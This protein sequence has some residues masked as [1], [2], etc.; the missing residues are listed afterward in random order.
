MRYRIRPLAAS[1]AVRLVGVPLAL[2][3]L[4]ACSDDVTS[5]STPIRPASTPTLARGGN[6][7]NN[8]RIVFASVRDAPTFQLYSMNAD[9]TGVS[10]LTYSPGYDSDPAVSP[11]GKRIVFQSNRD[12]PAASE[13]YVMNADG[14]GVTRLTYSLGGDITPAWSP[15]GK[16]IAFAS[17]RNAASPAT[18]SKDALDIYVMNADGSSVTQL[19]HRVGVDGVPSWSPDGK[20]IAFVSDRDTPGAAVNVY[21]MTADG[22]RVTPITFFTAANVERVAWSPGGKQ[23]A[24]STNQVF[25]V[26]ADGSQLTTLTWGPAANASP[27][28]SVDGKQIAFVSLRDGNN[29]IYT[30]NADGTALSRL[31]VN[32]VPD[33]FPAW[34]R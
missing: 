4:A 22:T 11:D 9:G 8:G 20:Q 25:V 5:P 21:T 28:W 19:T 1:T 12:E 30:M 15:D 18:G 7:D 26:N 31:T 24:F 34:G 10:R 14:T 29:E 17:T 23:I 32:S 6:G 27:S 33:A 2:A 16:R 3:A 13:I